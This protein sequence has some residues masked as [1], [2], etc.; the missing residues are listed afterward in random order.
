MSISGCKKM[1]LIF[2]DKKLTGFAEIAIADLAYG[3]I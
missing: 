2:Y 3:L 1:Q